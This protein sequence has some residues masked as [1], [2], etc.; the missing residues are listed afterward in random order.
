MAVRWGRWVPNLLSVC[1]F[2]GRDV[3]VNVIGDTAHLIDGPVLLIAATAISVIVAG[4]VLSSL[5]TFWRGHGFLLSWGMSSV[6]LGI[7]YFLNAGGRHEV[8]TVSPILAKLTILTSFGLLCLGCIVLA[9]KSKKTWGW[10]VLLILMVV[11][12]LASTLDGAVG[13]TAFL[14]GH[15]VGLMLPAYLL[16]QL[17]GYYRLCAL[18]FLFHTV[19]AFIMPFAS[20]AG[21]GPILLV[22]INALFLLQSMALILAAA[23]RRGE[24]ME[25]TQRA[26]RAA[27]HGEKRKVEILSVSEHQFRQAERIAGLFHWETGSRFSDGLTASENASRIYGL[28]PYELQGNVKSYLKYVHPEDLPRVRDVYDSLNEN[29][30]AYELEYRI[31]KKD[32]SLAYIREVGEP[33]FDSTGQLI[34]FQGTTQDVT[35]LRRVEKKLRESRERLEILA[36]S[37]GERF[38]EMG[39][40]LR[41]KWFKDHDDFVP[42]VDQGD[43][44]GR[45]RWEVANV[46]P[47]KDPRWAEHRALLMARKPFRDFVYEIRNKH[48]KS[49]WRSVSGIP[50]FDKD[51]QFVGYLGT[52]LDITNRRHMELERDRAL[53]AAESASRAK[54][55]FLAN[56]SHELRTPLNSIIG[57]SE[58]MVREEFGKHSQPKYVEYSGDIQNSATH[59]LSVI[60][61]ILDLS[62]VE[63]DQFQ[64]EESNFS[65]ASVVEDSLALVRL[66]AS[67]KQVSLKAEI[68]AGFPLLFADERLVKQVLVNLLANAVKFTDADGTVT[69]NA[70]RMDRNGLQ[71]CVTDTGIGIP[72]NKL[73]QALEPFGQVRNSAQVA[74]EGTG[75]G[76]PLSLKLM[77]LHGGTLDIESEEGKG[78]RVTLTF[79]AT[80]VRQAA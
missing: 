55:E 14:V 11:F 46:D 12:L 75:L 79:P 58:I 78:T 74:H 26:Y 65:V 5:H 70:H 51:K 59:L 1:A 4:I 16:F 30:R 28:E 25:R 40:D 21:V 68:P 7:G 8:I 42:L 43:I 33:N 31:L 24:T 6:L 66:P 80:R 60:D 27:I 52:S 61:D 53:Q 35:S 19:L 44:V 18:P 41:F 2:R 36:R 39:P 67:K 29:A 9:E 17:G 62:R 72:K 77:Q 37:S 32:G 49:G 57:F 63:S 76:L 64:P 47:D 10:P 71:I 20:E 15:A 45:T 48:G 50:V 13:G 69:I 3:T 73:A 56:M 23:I 38:W 22:V 54:S 34:N